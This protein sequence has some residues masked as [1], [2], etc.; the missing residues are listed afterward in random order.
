MRRSTRFSKGTDHNEEL[1]ELRDATSLTT[2]SRR[3]TKELGADMIMKPLK[4]SRYL[5]PFAPQMFR[6]PQP[7][8]EKAFKVRD[9]IV[10]RG[11]SQELTM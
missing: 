6:R 9:I 4:S 3:K 1:Q 11:Q 10:S 8:V 7:D 5:S 2:Y